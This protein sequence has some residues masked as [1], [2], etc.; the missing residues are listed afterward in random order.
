MILDYS[1]PEFTVHTGAFEITAHIDSWEIRSPA[2]ELN[3]MAEWSG[4]FV[5]A[6]T[7]TAQLSGL[8]E[9]DFSELHRPDR[10]RPGQSQFLI[11]VMGRSLPV[12]RID[13]YAYDPKTRTGKGSLVQ[14]TSILSGTKPSKVLDTSVGASVPLQRVVEKLIDDAMVPA[15][16]QIARHITGITG[17]LDAP[18]ATKDHLS[19]AQKFCGVNWHWLSI[20]STE[21]LITVTGD[22]MA[23]P[24]MMV[25]SIGDVEWEPDID[26]IFFTADKVIVTGACQVPDPSKPCDKPNPNVDEKGRTKRILTTEMQPFKKVFLTTGNAPPPTSGTWN[27]GTVLPGTLT[28]GTP[29]PAPTGGSEGAPTIAEKKTVMYRYRN[30]GGGLSSYIELINFNTGFFDHYDLYRDLDSANAISLKDV[31]EKTP[32]STVTVKEWPAGRIFPR[33]GTNTTLYVAEIEVISPFVRSVWVPEGMIRPETGDNFNIVRKSLEILSADRNHGCGG[34]NPKTGSAIVFEDKPKA[35]SL[36][37]APQVPLKT[38]SIRAEC[39]VDPAGWRPLVQSPH[40]V[41][42]GFLPSQ[43]HAD[44]LAKQISDQQVRRRNLVQVSEPLR[45]AIE[46]LDAGCPVVGRVRVHDG[47]FGFESVIAGMSEGEAKFSFA[48]GRIA[49]LSPPIPPS[50]SPLPYFPSAGLQILANRLIRSTVGVLTIT[51]LHPA[52]GTP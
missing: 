8:T 27:L 47:E 41:E 30:D 11:Q 51:P 14:Y 24:V 44:N 21:K 7:R 33:L 52:G 1:P 16:F 50:P 23:H 39:E 13:R 17:V 20:D 38:V 22:P 34:V 15:R 48:C 10:W 28:G 35:E 5:V 2:L 12:M 19:D 43:A 32:I 18:I 37:P 26:A 46:W 4:D 42:V 45:N 49:I 40:I 6:F 31:D 25:R 36:Q 9:Q 29:P 3:A